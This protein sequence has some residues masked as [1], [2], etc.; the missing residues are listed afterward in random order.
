MIGGEWKR[1][2]G[3]DKVQAVL[4]SRWRHIGRLVAYL[5]CAK[6]GYEPLHEQN[7]AQSN[8]KNNA[9]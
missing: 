5:R 6:F 3:I 9:N 7:Q 2:G 4:H 1:A 8:D